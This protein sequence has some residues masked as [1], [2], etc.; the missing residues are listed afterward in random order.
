MDEK[1]EATVKIYSAFLDGE[2][3]RMDTTIIE[4][5]RTI[6]EY[7]YVRDPNDQ[8]IHNTIVTAKRNKMSGA[9]LEAV[10][11]AYPPPYNPVA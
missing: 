11:R 9:A 8:D 5:I 10:L 6:R 7:V 1:V 3:P 4:A 2:S